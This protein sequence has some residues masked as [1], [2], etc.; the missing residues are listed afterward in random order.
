[1][2]LSEYYNTIYILL[3]GKRICPYGRRNAMSDNARHSR[4][5]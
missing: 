1:M 4:E 3:K 2:S 5:W